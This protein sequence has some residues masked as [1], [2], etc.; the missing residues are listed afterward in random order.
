MPTVNR[1][2]GRVRAGDRVDDLRL[3]VVHPD[4]SSAST[5]LSGLVADRPLLLFFWLDPLGP[6]NSGGWFPAFD[7]A[8]FASCPRLQVVG[9]SRASESVQDWYPSHGVDLEFGVVDDRDGTVAD[10]FGLH[11][12]QAPESRPGRWACFL[13]DET[14]T[15]RGRWSGESR[16]ESPQTG[17][18]VSTIHGDLDQII[19]PPIEESAYNTVPGT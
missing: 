16:A 17:P 9:V 10:A 5:S 1:F 2:M 4:G 14:L 11:D 19:G 15:V 3:T 13:L 6:D 12:R 18:S 8:W 7:L